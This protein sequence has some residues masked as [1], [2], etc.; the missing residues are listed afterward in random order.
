MRLSESGSL[1]N[2]FGRLDQELKLSYLPMI[3]TGPLQLKSTP[4]TDIFEGPF[5]ESTLASATVGG[6]LGN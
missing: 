1:L 6:D 5:S 2:E 4:P 3:A